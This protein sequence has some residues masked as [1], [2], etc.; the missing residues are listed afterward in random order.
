MAQNRLQLESDIATILIR[1]PERR[2]FENGY[3]EI[4]T[5][6]SNFIERVV[7]GLYFRLALSPIGPLLAFSRPVRGVVQHKNN[8]W[9]GRGCRS[10]DQSTGEQIDILSLSRCG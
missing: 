6:R 10:I 1:G 5:L 3:V 8:I 7:D 9:N 4:F 2:K